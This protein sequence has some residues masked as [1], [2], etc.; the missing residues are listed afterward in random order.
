MASNYQKGKVYDVDVVFCI[1]ATGS[2]TPCLDMV[3]KNAEKLYDDL[4]GRLAEEDRKINQMR[5]RLIA[6]R[7]YAESVK[8]HIPPMLTT[9]F[10]VLPEQTDYFKSSLA[11]IR[12]E[13]GGDEPEDGLEALAFAIKSKWAEPKPGIGR[14][15][16][17]VLWTDAPAHELGF[18]KAAPNYP[19][20]MAKDFNELTRWWG[21][22]PD[23]A[24]RKQAY[25]A[26]MDYES[27]RLL[28][29]AP[30]GPGWTDISNNWVNVMHVTTVTGEGLAEQDYNEIVGLLAAT[31][32]DKK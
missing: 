16:I 1:D 6:F 3:K 32:Q 17:I 8:D 27:K 30:K 14:R 11:S 13:G 22:K 28:I 19:E 15:Q 26:F 9:D 10:F 29:Y 18:G 12:P 7:D 24:A 21:Y 23:E 2:M 4:C 25:D 20:H 5:V 31:I